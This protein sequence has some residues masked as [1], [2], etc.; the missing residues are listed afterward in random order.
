[1]DRGAWQAIVHGFAKSWT[2][3]SD[4][5]SLTHSLKELEDLSNAISYLDLFDIYKTLNHH[6][7]IYLLWNLAFLLPDLP[8]EMRVYVDFL[9]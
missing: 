1:M 2:R 3:L 8:S 9:K 6:H 7:Y 4:C 5:H